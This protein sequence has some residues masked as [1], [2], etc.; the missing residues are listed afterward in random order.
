MELKLL[1]T[2]IHVFGAVVGFGGAI[3]SDAIFVS[4]LR[5]R[6]ITKTELRFLTL[7][8]RVVWIGLLVLVVSGFL[9]Y[10]TDAA[11]YNTSAK[12][13]SKMTVVGIIVLNGLLIHLRL[14]P[15]MHDSVGK[16]LRDRSAFMQQSSTFLVGG[17]ISVVSW[18]TTL[19]LG[20]WRGIPYLYSEIIFTYILVI[21]IGVVVGLLIKQS[22]FKG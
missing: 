12:F 6:K 2:M 1:Y 11:T 8:S 17:V 10:L 15:L 19:V 3:M 14:Y 7:G 22:I 20:L 9:L 21:C 13:L 16:R 5:D 4:S 18:F